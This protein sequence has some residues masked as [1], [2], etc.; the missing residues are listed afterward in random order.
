MGKNYTSIEN[1]ENYLLTDIAPEFQAQVG[2]WI[3]AM[4][5][6]IALATNREWL[7]D[8]TASTRLY[9]GSGSKSL[10]IDDCIDISQVEIG[11]EFGENFEVVAGY[12]SYPFNL[13]SKSLVILK[14]DIFPIGIQTAR[15]TA[16]WGYSAQVPQDIQHACTILVAGVIQAQTNKE[17]EI[18][19]E[20][21]GNYTVKYVNDAQKSD[22]QTVK[23]ILAQRQV[24]RIN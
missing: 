20:K 18:E 7:A 21:I 16:K 1:I 3:T 14:E 24:I 5:N 4:S 13:P 22:F 12:T 8:S 19:S 17:G 6:Y 23:D 11:E 15:I 10:R 9:N 2:L